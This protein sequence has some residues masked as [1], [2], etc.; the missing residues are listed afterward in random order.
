MIS[1][2]VLGN[3]ILFNL[4]MAVLLD[5]FEVMQEEEVKF[6]AGFPDIFKGYI[7]E[8]NLKDDKEKSNSFSKI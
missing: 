4:F 2:I 7:E 3:W 5:S 1:W 8:K 6:P